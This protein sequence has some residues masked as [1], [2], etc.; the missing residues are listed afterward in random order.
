VSSSRT[1]P[2]SHN[3][4]VVI[5]KDW[6]FSKERGGGRDYITRLF[7]HGSRVLG[8][9][10]RAPLPGDQ[11]V[12]DPYKVVVLGRTG[13]GKSTT[14]A[15]M[16]GQVMPLSH[17]E[18]GGCCVR[19]VVWPV[20]LQANGKVKV[21]V[22]DVHD[23]GAAFGKRFSYLQEAAMEGA[24]A[25]MYFFS[26]TDRASYDDLPALLKAHSELD[27]VSMIVGTRSD[28]PEKSQVTRNEMI[29]LA[30]EADAHAYSITNVPAVDGDDDED[31]QSRS[32]GA[33]TEDAVVLLNDLCEL[34]LNKELM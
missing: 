28:Q 12:S 30:K 17:V 9:L 29:R 6:H 22:L 33:S 8:V 4:L 25:V 34:L 7:P 5:D 15:N 19:R 23:L 20:R 27:V 13:T 14:V 10:D 11:P 32:V 16:A 3:R 31:F 2:A 21:M 1:A 18:T 24:H 26:H